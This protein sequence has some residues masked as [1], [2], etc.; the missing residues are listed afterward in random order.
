MPVKRMPCSASRMA[1]R[2]CASFAGS[3][4]TLGL[5]HGLFQQIH[6]VVGLGVGVM[7]DFLYGKA[8]L[9]IFLGK[10]LGEGPG[11]VGAVPPEASDDNHAV[12]VAAEQLKR[13]RICEDLRADHAARRSPAGAI[14]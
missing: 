9:D 13:I 3:P 6:D 8:S 2:S 14:P 5:F 1:V 10:F 12:G 7:R 4:V 11:G